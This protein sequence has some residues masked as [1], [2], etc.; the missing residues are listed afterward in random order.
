VYGGALSLA[1]W[2]AR[3]F[4]YEGSEAG[5]ESFLARKQ[6]ELD[7]ERQQALSRGDSAPNR[8][9]AREYKVES[10]LHLVNWLTERFGKA[11]RLGL[12]FDA[13]TMDARAFFAALP[14]EQQR[15]FLRGVYYAELKASGREYNEEGGKRRG[16]YLRGREAIATL[17]P[18][19]D[20]QGRP[21]S[22]EG[23]LTLFSSALYIDEYVTTSGVGKDR[24]TP[25]KTYISKAEWEAL[26]SPGYGVAFYDVLDAGIHT[27]FG[28]DV[29][30][31]TPGGRTLVGV[32]GGFVP[33]PGSG[34]MTQGEGD[35]DIY[36]RGSILMGQSR[37]FTTFGGNILGWSGE[38]DINAGRGAKTTVVYTPQRRVYDSVGNVT[39]SPNA[40]TTGAGIATLNPI[41]EIP[42]GDIDLIAPLGTIDAGEAGIRVSGNVNLA[43][44]R[45]VNAENIQVQGKSTGIPVV[46]AVN[47]GAL[48]N[49]S[50]AYDPKGVVQVL[51]AGALTTAQM[52]SLTP[53]ERRNLK[54]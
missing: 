39:L 53:G 16:S 35:I 21:R 25:G 4:G 48:S 17:L 11:N 1:Q 49:A 41:A 31:M 13:A 8:S 28:G 44:L 7:R 14:P 40:P 24:P 46:A 15:A 38:G 30:I 32:D 2:L 12:H 47:V 50:A 37:V 52:Q 45:V 36:A 42:P 54:Q 29:R 26:G 34:V 5:A 19:T 51:G 10:R 20:A 23:D 6:V 43:A 18:D 9:L 3:E 27:Q 33:G 22:Y